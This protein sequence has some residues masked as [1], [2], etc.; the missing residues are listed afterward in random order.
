MKREI[1]L[2]DENNKMED[3][4][5]LQLEGNMYFMNINTN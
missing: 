5:E 1:S 3:T 2:T 4:H